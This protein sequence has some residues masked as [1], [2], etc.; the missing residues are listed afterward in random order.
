MCTSFIRRNACVRENG[1][2]GEFW[3]SHSETWAPVP[4]RGRR[5]GL[6]HPRPAAAFWGGPGKAVGTGARG[7]DSV[8]FRGAL[9][10]AGPRLPWYSRHIQFLEKQN[11]GAKFQSTAARIWDMLSLCS[12][13]VAGGHSPA[14][15]LMLL[16]NM[17]KVTSFSDGERIY[18]PLHHCQG[19]VNQPGPPTL[20][21]AETFFLFH[22]C[23]VPWS[24][25]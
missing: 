9:P 8:S 16:D 25:T 13:T 7:V 11:H 4:E 1:K 23:P 19:M 15:K 22:P 10:V 3:K 24:H 2:E 6:Q 21:Q 14:L 5:A 18:P 12:H 17:Q 20:F